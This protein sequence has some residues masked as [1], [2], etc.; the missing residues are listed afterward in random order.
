MAELCLRAICRIRLT[1]ICGSAFP[2]RMAQA[3][4]R[5]ES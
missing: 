2:A 3:S 5:Q 1:H 4:A